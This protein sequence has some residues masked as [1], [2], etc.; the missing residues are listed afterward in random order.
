MHFVENLVTTMSPS[1]TWYS[2]VR[3]AKER[4]AWNSVIDLLYPSR[5]EPWPGSKLRSTKSGASSFSIVSRSASTKASIKRRASALFPS[6]VDMVRVFPSA[7]KV[8]EAI[9]SSKLY[10]THPQMGYSSLL[11][12]ILEQLAR[13]GCQQRF[14][15]GSGRSTAV[16][17][18]RKDLTTSSRL[19]CTSSNAQ[20]AR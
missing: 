5:L 7:D 4:A 3:S 18:D 10:L 17:T 15:R 13:K 12:R 9:I 14:E 20:K 8:D 6:S 2:K 11:P 1:A 16:R 19:V